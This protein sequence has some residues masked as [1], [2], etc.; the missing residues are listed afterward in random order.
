MFTLAAVLAAATA[1]FGLFA[2]AVSTIRELRI[3]AHQVED[4]VSV[5][6]AH[7]EVEIP[8]A[9]GGDEHEPRG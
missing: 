8:R 2:T 1:G 9:L 4:W 6:M 5:A 7:L 3:R